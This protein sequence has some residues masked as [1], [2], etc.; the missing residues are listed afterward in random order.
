MCFS[1]GG[2]KSVLWVDTLQAL[3]IV[4]GL[5]ALI[6]RGLILSGGMANVWKAAESGHR[7]NLWRY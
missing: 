3:I 5:I 1:Q 7:N 2:M 4:A 6:I